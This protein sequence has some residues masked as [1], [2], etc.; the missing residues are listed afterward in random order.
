[1][2]DAWTPLMVTGEPRLDELTL[3][4]SF[5]AAHDRYERELDRVRAAAVAG[6]AVS[7]TELLELERERNLL[8][9]TWRQCFPRGAVKPS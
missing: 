2:T 6:E 5:M 9:R 7:H 4:R 8:G 1:M 3:L